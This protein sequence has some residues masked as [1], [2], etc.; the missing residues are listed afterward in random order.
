MPCKVHYRNRGIYLDG[1]TERN[2]TGNLANFRAGSPP[3]RGHHHGRQWPLGEEARPAA[4]RRTSRR[5][6]CRAARHRCCARAGNRHAHGVCVF[7]RQLAAPGD[8]SFGAHAPVPPLSPLGDGTLPERRRAPQRHRTPRPSSAMAG[9]GDRALRRGHAP[10]EALAPARR[11]RLF[12]ARQH[13]RGRA[14]GAAQDEIRI[15]MPTPV[16]NSIARA[17]SLCSAP[18]IAT[19]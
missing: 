6:P 7:L 13:R 14:P 4:Y 8:G 10:R 19:R 3:A 18:S 16:S 11:S 9:Q 2:G 12:L 17:S 5:R 1:F 15:R